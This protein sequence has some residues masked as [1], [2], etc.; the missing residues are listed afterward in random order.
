[1]IATTSRPSLVN[2][3]PTAQWRRGEMKRTKN[4]PESQNSRLAVVDAERAYG[5][6]TS[7]DALA[8]QA[9]EILALAW[10]AISSE[11]DMRNRFA[12][13]LRK[14]RAAS[15]P[16]RSETIDNLLALD[17][18]RRIETD[19]RIFRDRRLPNELWALGQQLGRPSLRILAEALGHDNENEH[20]E[21]F[22]DIVRQDRG[23][24]WKACRI[25]AAVLSW[26]D[27]RESKISRLHHQLAS[28]RTT[29][30]R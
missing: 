26:P 30:T 21:L 23:K 9:N 20:W 17:W 27:A 18:A 28:A 3:E 6:M 29:R 4:A 14:H 25:A 2:P 5:A 12:A 11:G 7:E 1:M 16:V 10:A 15:K 19:E 8:M 22:A 24:K 13:T